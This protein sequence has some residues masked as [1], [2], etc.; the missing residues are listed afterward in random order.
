MTISLKLSDPKNSH[1]SES[2]A[3]V[4]QQA[5]KGCQILTNAVSVTEYVS[6][7][8]GMGQSVHP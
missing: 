8:P 4:F 1:D 3:A 2:R 5:V 6:A 7:T